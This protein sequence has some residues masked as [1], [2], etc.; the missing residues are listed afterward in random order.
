M[1]SQLELDHVIGFNGQYQS[2]LFYHPYSKDIVIYTIGSLV[3]IENVNE[4][5]AQQFLRG[6]DMEITALAISHAGKMIASGQKGTIYQ[7]T[8]DAPVILWDYDKKKPIFQLKGIQMDVKMLCFSP[9]DKYLA[10]YGGNNMLIIWDCRDGTPVHTRVFEFPLSVITWGQM[11]VAKNDKHPSYIFVYSNNLDIFVGTFEYDI[12]S[13]QYGMKQ[14]KC[15]LPSSGLKRTYTCSTTDGEN[16]Y[17]GT[18]GGEI[19]IFHLFNRIF[20]GCVQVCKNGLYSI[21]AS[22]GVIYA[23]GGDGK[24]KKVVTSD[25]GWSVEKEI[26]L[27]GKVTAISEH[28]EKVE[29]IVGTAAGKIYRALEKDLSY[30]IYA[31]AHLNAITDIAF[32]KSNDQFVTIEEEGF[33]FMW[34]IGDYKCLFS[35]KGPDKGRSV[36]VAEDD[37]V[38]AGYADGSM[39]CID[40]GNTLW[41]IPKCHKGNTNTIYADQNYILSGGDDG[42]V[43]VW[44]RKTHQLVMQLPAHTK[45]VTKILPDYKNPHLIHSCSIDKSLCSYNLKIEKKEIGHVINNGILLDMAQRRDHENELITCGNCTPIFFWDCD[46]ADPVAFIECPYKVFTLQVSPNGK[47]LAFGTETC[48]LIIYDIVDQSKLGFLAKGCA[49]SGPV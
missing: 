45:A 42:M 10:A 20:K 28:V 22:L 49:H 8:P 27:N 13:M 5:S 6:H 18:Q 32:G 47:Y 44:T 23:G 21:F 36:C 26:Q 3:L 43:R 4:R 39:K 48:E 11:Y 7:K 38:M 31:E 35:D 17:L 9:D 19:V 12:S 40:K 1:S 37:T 14:G 16:L 24:L 15:Q 29:I 46:V 25:K 30:F 33:V 34:D 2:T 41:T